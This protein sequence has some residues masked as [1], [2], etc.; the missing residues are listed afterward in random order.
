MLSGFTFPIRNMPEG[1]QW[2]TYIDPV[3]YFMEVVRGVFLQGAGIAT[4][5][6]QIVALA[7]YGV[8]VLW[9]SILRFHKQLE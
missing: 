2:L 1:V 6:P 7:I 9:L 4:L 5:W 8:I 3:R